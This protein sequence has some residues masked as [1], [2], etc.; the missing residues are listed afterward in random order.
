MDSRCRRFYL[1]STAGRVRSF[2]A[3]SGVLIK[4]FPE[5]VSKAPGSKKGFIPVEIPELVFAGEDHLLLAIGGNSAI[6]VYDEGNF[7]SLVRLRRLT[8]GHLG[9]E[10]RALAFSRHLSLV[11]TGAV[12]GSVTVWDY[13]MSRVE[14][15]CMFHTKEIVK[16]EFVEPYPCLISSSADG[17][18][19][20][21]SVRGDEM[22]RR[23]SCLC[24]F[25]NLQMQKG[26]S[27][28]AAQEVI[29]FAVDHQPI[30]FESTTFLSEQELKQRYTDFLKKEGTISKFQDEKSKSKVQ[31][32]DSSK[33][34]D[35]SSKETLR[36]LV[37]T[38]DEKGRIKI[39]DLTQL[40]IYYSIRA[41][42][43]YARQFGYYNPK[44]N[45]DVNATLQ[46][47]MMYRK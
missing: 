7:D 38:G 46:T 9:A 18:I 17:F 39:W 40:F 36:T 8:G 31:F 16:L 29:S 24:C 34:A 44:R 45:E 47:Q 12:N 23:Y 25:V 11:A 32:F 5:E 43:D 15:V 33:L 14:G 21:W 30:D 20:V 28:L 19:C 35:T 4:S 42:S 3:T 26:V 37:M 13:E 10:V 2:N 41:V 27:A 22:G 1:G 6:N